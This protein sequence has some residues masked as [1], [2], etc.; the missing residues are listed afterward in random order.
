MEVHIKAKRG[1]AGDKRLFIPDERDGGPLFGNKAAKQAN[2][3]H[4]DTHT[5]THTPTERPDRAIT[6]T[7]TKRSI[8]RLC[9]KCEEGNEAA[10]IKT[11]NIWLGENVASPSAESC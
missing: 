3:M 10:V 11:T 8:N 4:G 5:Q 2:R 6:V 9:L 7:I 1:A